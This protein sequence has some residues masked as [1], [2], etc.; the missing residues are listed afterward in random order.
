MHYLHAIAP[1]SL[2]TSTWPIMGTLSLCRKQKAC[3]LSRLFF[4]SSSFWCLLCPSGLWMWL[5]SGAH[6]LGPVTTTTEA[7]DLCWGVMAGVRPAYKWRALNPVWE[8]PRGQN[9]RILRKNRE[10]GHHV[11]SS[12]SGSF[13]VGHRT[14]LTSIQIVDFVFCFS[15]D[16]ERPVSL[17]LFGLCTGCICK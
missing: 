14:L 16:E 12:F 9:S 6:L 7:A 2:S 3:V 1:Q 10:W 4:Q 5:L 17:L 15:R 8:R 11:T 13:K